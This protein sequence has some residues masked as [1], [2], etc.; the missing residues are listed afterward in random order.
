MRYCGYVRF[1]KPK[2]ELLSSLNI[3]NIIRYRDILTHEFFLIF[4]FFI[5][6]FLA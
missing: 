1:M 5:F 2:P 6:S 3:V 4:Y